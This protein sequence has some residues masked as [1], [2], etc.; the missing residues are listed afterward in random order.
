MKSSVSV[1]GKQ[2]QI[3][4]W[5]KYWMGNVIFTTVFAFVNVYIQY[6]LSCMVST[7]VDINITYE[8]NLQNDIYLK[9]KK[10][11]VTG[12]IFYFLTFKKKMT[13]WFKHVFK[14]LHTSVK[15]NHHSFNH[16]TNVFSWWTPLVVNVNSTYL[17][18]S[19]WT[20]P[21]WLSP[22]KCLHLRWCGNSCCCVSSSFPTVKLLNRE[23][24]RISTSS[25]VCVAF[26][27]RAGLAGLLC[28]CW[29]KWREIHW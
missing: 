13:L 18:A 17:L 20:V 23:Q 14:H 3:V 29:N 28:V 5:N 27:W 10:K 6:T 19:F 2:L 12:M 26:H 4:Q 9:K 16:V 8:H 25:I 1:N 15:T 21:Q 7:A 24:E 22:L 11:K